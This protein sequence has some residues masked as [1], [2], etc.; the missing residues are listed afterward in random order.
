MNSSDSDIE[1][2]MNILTLVDVDEIGNIVKEHLETPEARVGQK[3]LAYEV[4]R[5]I[6]G[7][8]EAQLAQRIT[9]FLF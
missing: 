8:K 2:Y 7:D 6:H 4:V 9:Q 3:R 5:I 1:R